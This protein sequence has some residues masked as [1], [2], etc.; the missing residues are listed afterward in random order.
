MKTSENLESEAIAQL[1]SP[2]QQ[3][4]DYRS[5]LLLDYFNFFMYLL[6]Y[7]TLSKGP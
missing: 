6:V 4:G 7:I 3:F 2:L 5:V 1:L